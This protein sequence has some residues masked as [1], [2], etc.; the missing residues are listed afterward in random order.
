MTSFLHSALRSA[1]VL[2]AAITALAPAADF[3]QQILPILQNNCF[4]C[5]GPDAQKSGL[6]L[7]SLAQIFLKSALVPGDAESSR[8]IH[9]VRYT[10]KD[11]KMPPDGKLADADI[12]ALEAWVQVG[13]PW[14]GTTEAEARAEAK[15]IRE[16]AIANEPAYW[17]FRA[18]VKPAAPA[19]ADP[20]WAENPI[21]AFI[22]RKL[23]EQNLAPSREA[24]RRTLIRRLY[25][26]VLGL[27]PAPEEVD[28]FLADPDP[29][30]YKKLVDQVLASPHYGERWA[31]H[32]LDVV[33][34]AE[35]HGF[36]MNQPRDNAWRYRDYVIRAFNEDLPYTQFI[37]EQIAGDA[38]GA[39]AATGYLVAGPWDQVKSPD[40]VLTKNQR[41][42]E[43]HDMVN[44]TTAA[45][46]GLTVG[47]A[48][49]HD[50]KFDPISQRDY[51]QVRAFFAGVQHGDR[52]MRPPDYDARLAEAE[53]VASERAEVAAKLAAFAP[54]ATLNL[55]AIDDDGPLFQLA[56]QPRTSI[57]VRPMEYGVMGQSDI[58]PGHRYAI[59]AANTNQTVFAW[60]PDAAGDHRVY[61]SWSVDK[62]RCK[63]VAYVLDADGDPAT[64]GDQTVI[65]TID[66]RLNVAQQDGD[67]AENEWSGFFDA[68]RHALTESSAILLRSGDNQGKVT[69]DLIALRP[70]TG[71]IGA[72]PP[73][74]RPQLRPPVNF[75]RNE[76]R[77]PAI[78]ATALRFTIHAANQHAP[79]I[80]ELEVYAGAKNV[81]LAGNGGVPSA[82][83]E[84]GGEKHRTAHLNDG[85]YGNDRSWIHK[86]GSEGPIWAQ[87]DF[88]GPRRIDR[89]VWGRDRKGQYKD[90]LATQYTIEARTPGGDWVA[91]A[92]ALDRAPFGIKTPNVP[93]F[94]TGLDRA[95]REE[96]ANLKKQDAELNEK[97]AE[98]VNFP[99]IYAGNFVDPEPTHF[100][101]RG[102]PMAER[103]PVNPGGIAHV[104]AP[105]Q[106]P[107]DTP[108][109]K[110][111]VALADWLARGD[112]PLT[113]RVMVN[114][115]WHY[116]FGRG[117]VETP[118][119]FGAM[120]ARPTHPDLLDW[121]AV[122]FM[123][124]GWRPKALHRRI[125]LSQTYRQSSAPRPEALRIDADARYLWRFP[126]RRLEAEPIRDSILAASGVLDL[127][128]GGPGYNVFKPNENYVRVYDP[129]DE[130]GPEE[131]RRMIYQNKPRMEQDETFGIFDCPDGAQNQPKRNTSTTPLQ[132]LNLLNSPFMLQQ[133]ELFAQRLEKEAP[134][135][136]AQ[137]A[138][139]F[140]LAYA[141]QPGPEEQEAA[142]AFIQQHGLVLFCRAIYNTNEF[143]YLD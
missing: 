63:Q 90:R 52:E 46:L 60:Q 35:T 47:C 14:P 84:Y 8:I 2:L 72:A 126:P 86:E 135:P 53:Q 38:L 61:L 125:L 68:G 140:R 37:K 101:Y 13:A 1:A 67:T 71:D 21:D 114:R 70:E 89:A 64:D 103:E 3:E 25:L 11:L 7:D 18:P 95:D 77:F 33:G 138:R 142:A 39:D 117:I 41:D 62:D 106:L 110:R 58:D 76:D 15:A 93:Q 88:A 123:E 120:G 4:E 111:R 130:F 141:R 92:S 26:D 22:H 112:N 119:D 85:E 56:G 5:H 65:A 122:T 49:C 136:E 23:A 55:T 42:G 87:I 134:A 98:L 82:S 137:A 124:D 133:A 97:H 102:D 104:G 143:L 75:E 36:E 10:D 132:A 91:V 9:A 107:D 27:P 131:W 29:N 129:K 128:M 31:R 20:I 94:A 50:H 100:L 16:A 127:E 66:Q 99:K 74:Q 40:I 45:F 28:A 12:A 113:A 24:D 83:S 96:L 118:S 121:L 6:R 108:E 80:D 109:Q 79:C 69:A 105:L 34:F 139:A 59:W 78:E 19:V 17:A 81:A 43:L 115:I 51:Y 44:R 116:H 54:L 57:L 32:W 30:A 73:A 48:K